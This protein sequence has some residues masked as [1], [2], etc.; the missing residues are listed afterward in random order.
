MLTFITHTGCHRLWPEIL[1]TSNKN[2]FSHIYIYMY[3]YWTQIHCS[4]FLTILFSD[5]RNKMVMNISTV[6]FHRTV[7]WLLNSLFIVWK[8][9]D[10]CF[11]CSNF[12]SKYN[13]MVMT[14][15]SL[16]SRLDL[17][18]TWCIDTHTWST[19]DWLHMNGFDYWPNPLQISMTIID[20]IKNRCCSMSIENT[21]E[22]RMRANF[23]LSAY[24]SCQTSYSS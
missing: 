12:E 4:I 14:F 10:R 6:T 21:N 19:H 13:L 15:V 3:V 1:M 11:S 5:D 24:S 9:W 23:T 20:V 17:H 7:R 8:A 18:L 16:L 2:R 22:T